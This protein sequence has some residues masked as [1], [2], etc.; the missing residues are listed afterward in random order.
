[1]IAWTPPEA[2]RG[3]GLVLLPPQQALKPLTLGSFRAALAARI[4]RLVGQED[5]ED[6]RALLRLVADKEDLQ[7]EDLSQ[8]GDLLA[9]Q[10]HALKKAAAFPPEPVQPPLKAA[11]E[12]EA[13]LKEE[14]LEEFLSSLYY[15][16]RE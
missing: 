14:T 10:S 1:M 8:A 15:E 7:V 9:D 12:G 3:L 13:M 11:P 16:P 2:Q 4:N 6:A 5:P